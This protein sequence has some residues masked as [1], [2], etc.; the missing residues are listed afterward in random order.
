MENNN[1]TTFLANTRWQTV[2][3]NYPPEIRVAVYDAMFEYAA[4][5]EVPELDKES[6][7]AFLFIKMELDENQA[8]YEEK[9]ETN[10]MNGRM[11]GAPRGNQNARKKTTE[12]T[13]NNRPLEKQ[14]K[15][16]ETTENNH[17]DMICND[18]ISEKEISP[19]GDTKKAPE[20]LSP[21]TP[22]IPY[23]EIAEMWNGMTDKLPGTP[24][25]AKLTDERRRKVAQRLK[26]MGEK[27]IGKAIETYRAVLDRIPKSRFFIEKW[28]PSF[29]WLFA[30]GNNWVRIL[31]G[32]YG[33]TSNRPRGDPPREPVQYTK[34]EQIE[35]Y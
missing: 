19:D 1:K 7:M 29:D 30:N 3:K 23:Q 17:N 22:R 12:T 25:V 31:E 28:K 24:K 35:N 4:T 20:G 33:D 18:I 16:T 2:L 10:R 26:E 32:N 15:I 6:K 21:P 27:D 8:K 14:P 13:E 5:G 9:V 34:I 11:G